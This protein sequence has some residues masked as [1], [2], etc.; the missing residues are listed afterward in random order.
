M[1]GL[2]HLGSPQGAHETRIWVPVEYV[3]GDPRARQGEGVGKRGKGKGPTWG[4][5]VSR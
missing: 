4:A 1:Q 3:G 2:A 5:F